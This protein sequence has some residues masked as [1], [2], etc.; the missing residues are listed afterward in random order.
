MTNV[1]HKYIV[2][3]LTQNCIFQ[4]DFWPR[5]RQG[6]H[7]NVVKKVEGGD[8]IGFRGNTRFCM[9]KVYKNIRLKLSEKI[10]YS[11]NYQRVFVL[12]FTTV[13][14]YRGAGRVLGGLQLQLPQHFRKS[15]KN[16]QIASFFRNF[17]E[18]I[19][20]YPSNIFF[21]PRN[22]ISPRGP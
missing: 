11:K 7:N 21:S 5:S 14:R 10:K 2:P 15:A 9:N 17:I 19:G 8:E 20:V 13:D 4:L 18:K 6:G 3:H 12:N 1:T 16:G 22:K